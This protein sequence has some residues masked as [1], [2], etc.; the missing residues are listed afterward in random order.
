M[1][2]RE[3][4]RG[5]LTVL[6]T[7]FPGVR[8]LADYWPYRHAHL[9]TRHAPGL[10]ELVRG[11]ELPAVLRV[12]R[13]LRSQ[14][15]PAPGCLHHADVTPE[16][17]PLLLA[18]GLPIECV[19]INRTI[20]IVGHWLAAL[21]DELGVTL[22][23]CHANLHITPRGHG[24]E[25]HFD[26]HDVFVV[27]LSG[28]KTFVVAPNEDVAYP[29]RS[30]GPAQRL[31]G[32]LSRYVDDE[33][34]PEMPAGAMTYE[35]V[36]GSALYIPRGYWHRTIGA[37][38]VCWSMSLGVLRPSWL[39]V[40]TRELHKRLVTLA[41]WREPALPAWGAHAGSAA[42]QQV[43][44][45]LLDGLLRDLGPLDAGA[46]LERFGASPDGDARRW[47]W[48]GDDD[49]LELDD[50]TREI[51]GW[52]RARRSFDLGELQ[53]R[54]PLLGAPEAARLIAVLH[55][56]GALACDRGDA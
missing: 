55:E 15:A 14:L 16:Q 11:V 26:N 50:V 37:T 24:L 21:A 51:V 45:G 39:D 20:P 54:F 4:P 53:R 56:A 31:R 36:A 17:V 42:A 28:T 44:A 48:V 18:A 5:D 38:D 8:F 46:L 13:D 32:E 47:T 6:D 3:A 41:R 25:K 12:H 40:V 43:L 30:G 22:D 29:S 23:R 9:Y 7:L 52:T 10:D 49:A 35:V 27:G 19:K 2:M 33:F 34:D 1:T